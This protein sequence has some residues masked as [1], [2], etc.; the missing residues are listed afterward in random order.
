MVFLGGPAQGLVVGVARTQ[1]LQVLAQQQLV[2][3]GT[4]HRLDDVGLDIHVQAPGYDFALGPRLSLFDDLLGPV[5]VVAVVPV[6]DEVLVE[7]HQG[8]PDQRPVRVELAHEGLDLLQ[9]LVTELDHAL[10]V[11][12]HHPVLLGTDQ[13]V[14]QQGLLNPVLDS[15]QVPDVGFLGGRPLLKD[16]DTVARLLGPFPPHPR[17]AHNSNAH[18]QLT[19]CSVLIL[20]DS[21]AAGLMRLLHDIYDY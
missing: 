17:H 3:G 19:E 2:L 20:F 16:V 1:R 8:L 13:L 15:P 18:P 5:E 12:E 7:A 4:L 21:R 6:D 9:H 10:Q 14:Q 11:G